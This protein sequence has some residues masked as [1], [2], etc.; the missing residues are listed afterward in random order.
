MVVAALALPAPAVAVDPE[1]A[2]ARIAVA[3]RAAISSGKAVHVFVP[4]EVGGQAGAV[5]QPGSAER[6]VV[7]VTA[8]PDGSVLAPAALGIAR[9]TGRASRTGTEP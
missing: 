2:R 3:R 8:L 5:A 7:A 9:L 6:S 1:G 4:L